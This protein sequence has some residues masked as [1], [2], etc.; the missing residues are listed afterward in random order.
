MITKNP[1]IN[2]KRP[3]LNVIFTF[4]ILLAVN[5]AYARV[6]GAG[7]SSSSG[8]DGGGDGL[9]GLVF[10][11][12]MLI[13]FP[14]N[15]I[16]IAIILVL[17]YFGMKKAK[18]R[19]ILNQMPSGESVDK[20]KGYSEFI[21]HNPNFN[22]ASFKEKVKT[23]FM[24]IQEAWQNK[25]MSKVRKYISDGMYQRL[26]V[27]FKMMDKLSQKNTIDKLTVKNIYIDRVDTDGFFDVVHVAIHASIVDRFISDK[28]SELN[29]GGSEEF[30]EYWSYLK[31]RGAEEKDM[32]SSDNCPSCGAALSKETAEVAKCEFCGTLTNSGE[33][34]WVLAE[35]TQ[36]DDYISSNPLVIKATN[37]QEKVIEI[38]QHNDDF[39]IQLIE[40][41]ASNAFLQVE[42]ARVLNDPAILR[43]FA[44]DEA[45][46]KI[47]ATFNPAEPFVYNRIFLSDVTLI[48]ALQ[49]DN[50]NTMIVSIKYSYQRV[51]PKEKSVVKLDPVVVTDTKIILLS[52]NINP[53]VSKGSLYA[54][55]CPS[56]GGPVGDTIDLK[57]QY[58]GH[59]LNSPANE[60]IVTDL[61]TLNDYYSYYAMN[62]AA[63]AGGIKPNAI[64][65][66]LD[67]RD[68]A[69]NNALI[70]MACD[71]V[72]AQE[73]R[74]YAEQLAKKFGYNV[75]KVEPMFQMA[76]NGQLSLKMPEDQK[77]REKVFRL[78]EKA[79]SI[80]GTVDPNE[81]QLLDSLK[82]QYGFN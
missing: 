57:C 4:L 14:Y 77:K 66:V 16:V 3:L 27:Q 36:A 30:V 44:S 20:V 81:R 64:D 29:S 38:E 48:G 39:S 41:K 55:R 67:V 22:E 31:K 25:D 58:C 74:D 35:I 78:M 73:E 6:G 49:K 24:Q 72:F 61:M 52:R 63:F 50:M 8:G 28:Y 37:L 79:A 53:E 11:I 21:Q 33:Y 12:L 5:Y 80:D 34:D 62:G 23:S 71:G 26:N 19:T 56:C 60:W 10:Y 69:F 51:L 17:A 65:N 82:Q 13:P 68:Y 40:D 76:Q 75:D 2:F 32:F 18:Q 45:F 15:L 54:H 9:I 59:E 70:V 47:K 43:R 1:M 46:E 7:G 42:T